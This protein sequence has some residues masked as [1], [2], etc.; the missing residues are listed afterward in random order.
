MKTIE[1]STLIVGGGQS[2][3]A[4]SYYLTLYD[5]DHIVL[6]GLKGRR[7]FGADVAG[8]HSPW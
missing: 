3:L 5:Q 7:R 4:T 2:G 6:E 1:T 8:I